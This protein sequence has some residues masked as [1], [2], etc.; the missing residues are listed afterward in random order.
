MI[1]KMS[2]L[3]KFSLQGPSVLSQVKQ[4]LQKGNFTHPDDPD[5]NEFFYRQNLSFKASAIK[6]ADIFACLLGLSL[7]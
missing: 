1:E 7:V 4:K 3:C 6:L 5:N 2:F